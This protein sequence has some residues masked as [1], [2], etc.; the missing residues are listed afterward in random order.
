MPYFAHPRLN[1]GNE[2]DHLRRDLVIVPDVIGNDCRFQSGFCRAVYG[3]P[4]QRCAA[5]LGGSEQL[6]VKGIVYGTCKNVT[7][8][9]GDRDWTRTRKEAGLRNCVCHR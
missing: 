4:V 1:P 5:P 9:R 3:I 6:F 7:F 8:G 2:L